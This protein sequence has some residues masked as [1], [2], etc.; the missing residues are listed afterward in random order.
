MHCLIG[1]GLCV[2]GGSAMHLVSCFFPIIFL[3]SPFNLPT[4]GED[5]SPGSFV[6][7]GKLK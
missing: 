1:F 2:L 5:V 4:C 7:F 6:Y 3:I